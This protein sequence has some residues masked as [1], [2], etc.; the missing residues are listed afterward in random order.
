VTEKDSPLADFPVVERWTALPSDDF[1]TALDS[2]AAL[3]RS[4]PV[5]KRAMNEAVSALKDLRSQQQK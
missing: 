4:R 3:G 2:L 1:R 5:L